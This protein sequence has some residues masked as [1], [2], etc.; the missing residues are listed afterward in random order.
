MSRLAKLSLWMVLALS[1]A[2]AGCGKAEEEAQRTRVE[3]EMKQWLVSKIRD[4]RSAAQALHDAAPVPAGRGWDKQAD[5]RAIQEMKDAWGRAREAYELVEGAV[6]PLFPESDTAT[7]AR[8]DDFLTTLGAGGDPKPFDAEGIVGVHAIERILWA[9]SIPPETVEFEKGLPGYRPAAFPATEAEAREFKEELSAKLVADI[10]ALEQQLAP[11]ELDIAFAFRGLIDLTN[12]QLEKVDRASTGREESRYA[13]ST[14]RDL[15]ANREGCW[16]AYQLFQPW[17]LARGGSELDA[18]V[19]ASFDRL[20]TT[21]DALPGSAI[22]RPPQ[23]WSS[24]DPKPEHAGTPFG[25]L[26]QV[27][28]RETDDAEK[29]SLS[30]SLMAVADTLGLPKAVLR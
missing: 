5:A 29:G 9:D 18:Q 30:T 2:A 13:Q 17:L 24:L 23:G 3:K 28:K 27:V 1:P 19:R 22:P 12:E 4:F 14:L 7:D 20:K 8:Y 16:A 26:F 11:V 6:A 10:T 15:R 25:R 21:Y